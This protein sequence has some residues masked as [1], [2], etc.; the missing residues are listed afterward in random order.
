MASILFL[1]IF[2]QGLYNYHNLKDLVGDGIFAVDGKK[3]RE[4]RKLL[5][6]EFSTKMLRDFSISIFRKNA[7]KLANIVSEAATSNSTLEIQVS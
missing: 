2:V 7:A 3:W 1:Q 5:S 4:Q 6:H